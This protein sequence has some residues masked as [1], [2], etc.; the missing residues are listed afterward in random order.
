MDVEAARAEQ[1][2][3]LWDAAQFVLGW[4]AIIA[5]CTL[6]YWALGRVHRPAAPAGPDVIVFAN[7]RDIQ[8]GLFWYALVGGITFVLMLAAVKTTRGAMLVCAAYGSVAAGIAW[9]LYT[10]ID[11]VAFQE[12][13]V[14][15]R[16]LWPRPPARLAARDIV[17]ADYEDR[18]HGGD[19]ALL[20][21]VLHLRTSAGDHV[22]FG[23]TSLTDV[24]V[25][26][27]RI[28]QMQR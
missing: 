17:S 24:Q 14:E 2:K 9:N 27:R 8:N 15:L 4:A 19:D 13:T 7:H 11:A 10:Q 3:N 21:Y 23:D 22:S 6:V 28:K 20:E 18:V 25:T 26:I 1:R 5:I 12:R 16:Y